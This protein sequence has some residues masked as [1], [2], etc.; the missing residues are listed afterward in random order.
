MNVVINK[1]AP[2]HGK[3]QG[4]PMMH[5]EYQTETGRESMLRFILSSVTDRSRKCQGSF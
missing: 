3:R 4:R 1:G 2:A 5:L